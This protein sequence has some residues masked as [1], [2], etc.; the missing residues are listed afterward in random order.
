MTKEIKKVDEETKQKAEAVELSDK[1]LSQV[2]GGKTKI[3]GSRSNI[4]TN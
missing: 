2:A 1:E 3:N 4:K